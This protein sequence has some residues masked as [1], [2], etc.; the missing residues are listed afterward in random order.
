MALKKVG[1][2]LL[3]LPVKT[4]AYCAA[5]SAIIDG[6]L[7]ETA[8]RRACYR[9]EVSLIAGRKQA[10]L[11]LAAQQAVTALVGDVTPTPPPTDLEWEDREE[12]R[13]IARDAHGLEGPMW[14]EDE[15]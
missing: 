12:A 6:K 15:E 10:K 8:L 13:R 1:P 11:I 9:W 3:T 14:P 4:R 5:N 7:E 2:Y